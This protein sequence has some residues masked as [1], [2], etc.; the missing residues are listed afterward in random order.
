[1]QFVLHLL[2]SC[3]WI[4]CEKLEFV[5]ICE[6]DGVQSIRFAGC[7]SLI[8]DFHIASALGIEVFINISVII[9]SCLYHFRFGEAWWLAKNFCQTLWALHL[10]Q[11]E[12][13][14]NYVFFC[15]FRICKRQPC[16]KGVATNGRKSSAPVLLCR[17]LDERDIYTWCFMVVQSIYFL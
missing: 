12:D 5:F 10:N 2:K 13:A 17:S 3:I 15:V 16:H 7:L 6:R 11:G 8:Y 9:R 14:L 4:E 1:M